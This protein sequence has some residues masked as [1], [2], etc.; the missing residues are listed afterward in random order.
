MQRSS[1]S[2]TDRVAC[3]CQRNATPAHFFSSS[4][5]VCFHTL[6]FSFPWRRWP[7]LSILLHPPPFVLCKSKGAA[8]Q[9]PNQGKL[10]TKTKGRKQGRQFLQ[11]TQH[12]LC[13]S[14]FNIT[15][16]RFL[17]W[18]ELL[19]SLIVPATG[20]YHLNSGATAAD[21][22]LDFIYK[23]IEEQSVEN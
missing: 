21:S 19:Q 20:I 9:F 6:W 2:P 5:R 17:C 10:G 13:K 4:V 3:Q 14:N 22:Y 12:S 18:K 1:A 15:A 7:S 8:L 16:T 11:Q 23:R